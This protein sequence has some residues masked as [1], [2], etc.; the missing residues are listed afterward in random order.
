MHSRFVTFHLTYSGN[1]CFHPNSLSPMRRR[2][3]ASLWSLALSLDF[4]AFE[5]SIQTYV[6]SGVSRFIS[7]G[8]VFPVTVVTRPLLNFH[9]KQW[10]FFLFFCSSYGQGLGSSSRKHSASFSLITYKL[11]LQ[12]CQSS[13][14]AFKRP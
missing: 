12:T 4:A 7:Y 10:G 14:L 6:S 9:V 1:K 8:L 13:R 11:C 5:V 3:S 2:H